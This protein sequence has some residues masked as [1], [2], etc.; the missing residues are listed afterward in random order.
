MVEH[1]NHVP[2]VSFNVFARPNIKANVVN[3]VRLNLH[4]QKIMIA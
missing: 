1:V 3:F 2:T 4:M